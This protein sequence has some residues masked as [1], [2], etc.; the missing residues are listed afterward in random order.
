[1]RHIR[2]ETACFFKLSLITYG[3][4]EKAL[5]FTGNT[6]G[7]T[8]TVPLTSCMTGLRSAV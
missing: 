8:I 2:N 7:G 5:Q 1:M 6:K 4:S 3:A